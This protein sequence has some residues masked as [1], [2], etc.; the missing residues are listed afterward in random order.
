VSTVYT[1]SQAA[2]RSKAVSSWRVGY[3]LNFVWTC[4]S[5]GKS[6][7]CGSANEAWTRAA[8][9][10]STGTPPAGAPVYFR[11]GTYGHIAISI[12]GGFIRS[13]DFPTKG[14]VGTT[15]I[16]DLCREWYGTTA[17]YRGWSRDLCGDPIPGL[18]A[19]WHA[20][21]P[22]KPSNLRID[23]SDIRPGK[24]DTASTTDIARFKA[25]LWRRMSPAYRDK[26]WAAWNAEARGYW[27]PAGQQVLFDLYHWL[28][29]SKGWAPV[30]KTGGVWPGD[31]VV[32]NVGG[33]PI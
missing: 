6:Y 2:Q 30:S 15:T 8:Q 22:A 1:A 21:V 18:Q 14:H 12:G 20:P 13:T 33:I 27:G 23:V 26:H 3:C 19:V 4:I 28:T 5:A 29:V 16:N 10:V 17:N 11:G 9:K 32:K 25:L 24:R 7:N 31:N